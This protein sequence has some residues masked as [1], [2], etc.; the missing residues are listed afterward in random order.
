MT[1]ATKIPFLDLVSSHHELESELLAV[2]KKAFQT[3]GFI[4]GP[5]VEEF[6]REFAKLHRFVRNGQAGLQT[7][8]GRTGLAAGGQPENR[9]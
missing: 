5:M 4:G 3:A 2:A 7:Q 1:S 8:T 6:E 9:Q